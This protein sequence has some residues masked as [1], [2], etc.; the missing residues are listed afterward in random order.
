MYFLCVLC[1]LCVRY[2]IL[3]NSAKIE[4]KSANLL[5]YSVYLQLF[6]S[7]NIVLLNESH[8]YYHRTRL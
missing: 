7:K 3:L 4:S 6:L 1:V 2:A 8:Y 5:I